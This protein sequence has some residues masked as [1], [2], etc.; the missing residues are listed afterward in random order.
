MTSRLAVPV[1]AAVKVVS[2]CGDSACPVWCRSPGGD[3]VPGG[4]DGRL[5]LTQ[6][7]SPR[8]AIESASAAAASGRHWEQR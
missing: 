1:T 3:G 7:T 5:M 4:R 8:A 6:E 2:G